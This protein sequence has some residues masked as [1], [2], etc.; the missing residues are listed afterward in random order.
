MSWV[1][2]RLDSLWGSLKCGGSTRIWRIFREFCIP[3]PSSRVRVPF[4][5]RCLQLSAN[6]GVLRVCVL[7][8]VYCA[9]RI[10]RCVLRVV[11]CVLRGS[12]RV[13][14][15]RR[16]ILRAERVSSWASI[17]GSLRIFADLWTADLWRGLRGSLKFCFRDLWGVLRGSLKFCF[18]DLWGVLRGSLKFCFRDLWRVLRG[19]LRSFDSEFWRVLRGSLWSFDSEFWRVL[20]EFWSF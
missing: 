20:R 6:P 14:G 17:Q 9:L 16:C 19:S 18:R 15:C 7:R 3:A 4:D 8:V 11:C 12:L 10:V 13:V 5:F 2:R 1:L